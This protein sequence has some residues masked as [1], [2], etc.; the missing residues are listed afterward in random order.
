MTY[1]SGSL[2]Q[3][4]DY[5]NFVGGTTANVSGQINSIWSTGNG[6]AGYGQTTI[7]N[8]SALGTV[9][10]TQWTTLVNGLNTI[11]KHQSGGSFSN[12]GT[13]SVGTLINA[14]TNF[15]SNLNT[16]FDNRLTAAATSTVTGSNYSS[17]FTA[18]SSESTASA[19]SVTFYLTRTATFANSDA[20]RYFFNAGGSLTFVFNSNSTNNNATTRSADLLT[21][22]TTRLSSK[23]VNAQDCLARTGTGGTLN[24]D[25]QTNAG[26]YTRTTSNVA[27]VDIT[28]TVYTYTGDN[29]KLYG[30]TNGV[31]GSNSDNG[32][33]FSF[34]IELTAGSKTAS[35]NDAIDVTLN[36]RV[37]VNYPSSGFL[38]NTWGAV[39]IA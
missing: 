19:P 20:A 38:A 24:A 15:A 27:L 3:A 26:Y 13:Y 5:N 8:V 10:A 32:T 33:V 16:A 21:L 17:N 37:D 22:A 1:V 11:R 25:L 9:T 23:T 4:S 34:G 36:H 30:K 14:T 12:L 35:Y 6:N 18:N 2:I 39:T 31:Q 29:I 28:S 7:A